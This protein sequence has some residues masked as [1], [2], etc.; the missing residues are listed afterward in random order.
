MPQHTFDL[1]SHKAKTDLL[2]FGVLKTLKLLLVVSANL[3]L[4]PNCERIP[5]TTNSG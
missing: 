4:I 1:D 3:K 2:I 5:N